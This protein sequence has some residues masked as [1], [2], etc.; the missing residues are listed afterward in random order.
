MK[1]ESLNRREILVLGKNLLLT[2]LVAGIPVGCSLSRPIGEVDW[3][4]EIQP[5]DQKGVATV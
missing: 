3:Q 1:A 5:L 2:S 4:K